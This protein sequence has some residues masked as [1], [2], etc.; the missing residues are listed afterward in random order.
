MLGSTS[1]VAITAPIRH[2]GETEECLGA[3][4]AP[5]PDSTE[6]IAANSEEFPEQTFTEH[7]QTETALNSPENTSDSDASERSTASYVIAQPEIL[8]SSITPISTFR[9]SQPFLPDTRQHPKIQ[10]ALRL[11]LFD[12]IDYLVSG[13]LT[14]LPIWF[15]TIA[16]Y[17]WSILSFF[18]I[19]MMRWKLVN[20]EVDWYKKRM[21]EPTYLWYG[22][23]R[24]EHANEESEFADNSDTTSSRIL[25]RTD[26]AHEQSEEH[27]TT[28][29]GRQDTEA[30]IGLVSPP[31]AHN[32]N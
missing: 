22:M 19:M 8:T 25:V 14:P 23:E 15:L 32:D 2:D 20:Y 10:T 17:G 3:E 24:T 18:L 28:P 21:S 30:D 13:I 5:Q 4:I 6:V 7:V 9:M 16:L 26:Q 11:F 12:S 27:I 31:T 1:T 29:P